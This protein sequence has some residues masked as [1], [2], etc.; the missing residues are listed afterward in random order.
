M[1][2]LGLTNPWTTSCDA[3]IVGA[4]NAFTTPISIALDED[5]LH[6]PA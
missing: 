2:L 5:L 4:A 1:S 3:P 6:T